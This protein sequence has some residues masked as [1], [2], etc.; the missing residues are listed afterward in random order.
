METWEKIVRSFAATTLVFSLA[1]GCRPRP[2]QPSAL[3]PSSPPVSPVET[4]LP[5]EVLQQLNHEQGQW[6]ETSVGLALVADA[7]V[8]R[9]PSV[10]IELENPLPI[11]R[12]T[13]DLRSLLPSLSA[14]P[15]GAVGVYT[16]AA[17]EGAQLALRGVILPVAVAYHG[18]YL[19]GTQRLIEGDPSIPVY[20]AEGNLVGWRTLSWDGTVQIQA[21]YTAEDADALQQ[22]AENIQAQSQETTQTDSPEMRDPQQVRIA[23]VDDDPDFANTRAEFLEIVLGLN[24]QNIAHFLTCEQLLAAHQTQP[25]DLIL[26]DTD[27]TG[28]LPP[29]VTTDYPSGPLCVLAI[30][31][32]DPHTPIIGMSTIGRDE[33]PAPLAQD[34]QH[35]GAQAFHNKT[36]GWQPMVDLVRQLLNLP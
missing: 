14:L 24:S 15:E 28:D 5:E 7:A 29:G 17:A 31:E 23:I 16:A 6:Q 10:F 20:D 22:A 1:A 12:P 11:S 2:E 21:V 27:L 35:F 34:Y 30:R 33:D 32:I 25:F 8:L 18:A 9:Q 4:P 36:D 13:L 26:V 3:P 19:A